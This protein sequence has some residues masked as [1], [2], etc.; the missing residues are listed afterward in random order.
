MLPYKLLSHIGAS[1]QLI[2][3]GER[4]QTN[5]NVK[6]ALCSLNSLLKHILLL[7]LQWLFPNI[8]CGEMQPGEREMSTYIW[9][10]CSCAVLVLLGVRLLSCCSSGFCPTHS[11]P[12]QKRGA[13]LGP[14]FSTCPLL[15][16]LLPSHPHLQEVA[17]QCERWW[18]WE[19][20]CVAL[21]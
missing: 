8:D 18:G 12:S 11:S 15:G 1:W 19:K 6:I 14:A 7:T 5:T 9:L 3:K 21:G 10:F 20:E 17:M 2:H 4:T 16:P 13:D